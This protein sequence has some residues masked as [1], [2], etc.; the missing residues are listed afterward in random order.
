MVLMSLPNLSE[1][2]RSGKVATSG[3][4]QGPRSDP[5]RYLSAP[6]SDTVDSGAWSRQRKRALPLKGLLRLPAPGGGARVSRR[7]G[8]AGH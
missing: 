8:Q 6:V 2:G 7:P 3:S 1:T 4:A 5:R